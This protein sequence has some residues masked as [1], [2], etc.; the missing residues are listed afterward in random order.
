MVTA[1]AFD[2]AE[3]QKTAEILARELPDQGQ[4]FLK[5]TR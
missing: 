3:L 1:C 4:A 2:K 5:F